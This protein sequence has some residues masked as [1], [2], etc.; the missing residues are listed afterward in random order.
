MRWGAAHPAQYGGAHYPAQPR[1]GGASASIRKH[2]G[3]SRIS[4]AKRERRRRQSRTTEGSGRTSGT[5]STPAASITP[6]Y[7]PA[8]C[9]PAG[10]RSE[11]GTGATTAGGGTQP[12]GQ[13]ARLRSA[14][15]PYEGGIRTDYGAAGDPSGVKKCRLRDRR[16]RYDG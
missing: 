4:R 3:N 11:Y 14:S 9:R 2:P 13:A 5:S 1:G 7:D 8:G 6:T 12:N 15:C 16:Q 10:E